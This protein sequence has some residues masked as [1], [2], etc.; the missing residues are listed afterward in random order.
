MFLVDGLTR[1]SQ[2]FGDLGPGP[3][4][5]HRALDLGVLEAVGHGSEGSRGREAVGGAAERRRFGG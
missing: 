2:R 1:Y 5:A 4:G 3:P